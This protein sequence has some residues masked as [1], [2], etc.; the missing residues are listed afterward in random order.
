MLAFEDGP[1]VHKTSLALF[2]VL[3]ED[4]LLPPQDPE[5]MPNPHRQISLV[6][7]QPMKVPGLPPTMPSHCLGLLFTQDSPSGVRNVPHPQISAPS[8]ISN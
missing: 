8:L 2:L 5:T 7:T 1:R 3:G 6:G 4:S